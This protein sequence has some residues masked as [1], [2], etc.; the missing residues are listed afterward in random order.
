MSRESPATVTRRSR[1]AIVGAAAESRDGV[2]PAG[3][4]HLS[5]DSAARLRRLRHAAL[6]ALARRRG[7]EDPTTEDCDR[8]VWDG[9]LAAAYRGIAKPRA[10]VASPAAG[11]DAD[12][13]AST[14]KGNASAA[15]QTVNPFRPFPLGWTA[16]VGG[17]SFASR[18]LMGPW[19]S[20]WDARAHLPASVPVPTG[21]FWSDFAVNAERIRLSAL[22]A[23]GDSAGMLLS[24]GAVSSVAIVSAVAFLLVYSRVGRTP[25]PRRS[26]LLVSATLVLLVGASLN[27]WTPSLIPSGPGL[28]AFSAL[29][30]LALLFLRVRM[31]RG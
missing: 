27:L 31:L 18:L 9:G 20:Y 1:G 10:T 29:S 16:A 15:A 30:P 8:A 5:P 25:A 4:L 12:T 24:L 28:V 19:R 3:G 2:A 23:L 22:L 7:E 11:A 26:A 6:R 17:L 21:S 13:A 14:D